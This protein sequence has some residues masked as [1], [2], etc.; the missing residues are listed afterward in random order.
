MFGT[1]RCRNWP[2]EFIPW[3]SRKPFA[4]RFGGSQSPRNYGARIFAN[5]AKKER[6][7]NLVEFSEV[8]YPRLT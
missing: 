1:G 2:E 8:S 5:E 3:V 4:I 7:A 6:A